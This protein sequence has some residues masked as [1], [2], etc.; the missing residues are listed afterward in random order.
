MLPLCIVDTNVLVAGLLTQDPH[1]P[2]VYL[3][4]AMVEGSLPFLFSPALV[5]EY[6][7]V[8]ARPKLSKLHKLTAQEQEHF[9]TELVANS[10]WR[11]P[12]PSSYTPPDK[13]DAH[14][15]SLLQSE[16]KAILVTGDK[17]LLKQP[18]KGRLIYTP[19]DFLD[20]FRPRLI[21][22]PVIH[23]PKAHPSDRASAESLEGTL[24]DWETQA[25]D[26]AYR[27]L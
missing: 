19:T 9:L 27:D 2:T 10:I 26:D 4:D 18:P 11:E 20:H 7:D 22:R 21:K 1:S 8:L 5:S 17:L 25:D 12:S 6:K 13:G 3:V 23:L 15:W 16:P 24:T 14:L